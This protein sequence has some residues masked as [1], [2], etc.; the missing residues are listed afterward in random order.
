MRSALVT[1]IVL[2]AAAVAGASATR[3]DADE[4]SAAGNTTAES[5]VQVCT[6][7]HGRNGNSTDPDVPSLA[8]QTAGYLERQLKAFQSQR[9]VGVMSGVSM[10]LSEQEIRD[11]TNYFA[12][13]IP[14]WA[15]PS[16]A[17]GALGSSR[18]GQKIWVDGIAD[19][20]VP[21]CAS[22]HAL[23]GSG[24]APEFPRLAGQHAPYLAAQLRAFRSDSRM[25]NPNKMMREVSA[26]LSDAD[27][28]AVARYTAALH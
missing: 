16:V 15:S 12:R 8:G 26:K 19:K 28:E 14:H 2:A 6:P 9:R 25:S 24:L 22:C 5:G 4:I 21:A 1:L 27:I 10:V 3:V 13:Q 18:R 7:C 11:T 23:D 17:P 20:G